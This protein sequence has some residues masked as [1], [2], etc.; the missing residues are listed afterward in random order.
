MGKSKKI[1]LGL[2]LIFLG[3]VTMVTMADLKKIKMVFCDVGQGDGMVLSYGVVQIVVDVGPENG[4]MVRCLSRYLPFWDKKIDL[5]LLSH[6]DKDHSGGVSEVKKYYQVSRVLSN[7]QNSYSGKVRENDALEVGPIQIDIISSGDG[8]DNDSSLV[9]VV[10]VPEKRILLM[11][12]VS[13]EVEQRLVWRGKIEP[14]EIIKLSHHGS[15]EASGEEIL[16]EAKPTEAIIS[17]GKNNRYGHP[18]KEVIERL[19]AKGIV[20]RRTDVEG[21]IVYVV[22]SANEHSTRP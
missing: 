4:K 17:V 8:V 9:M 20:T 22:K 11:G 15:T 14:V 1:V 16:L 21:D 3:W 18:G 19:K 7:E 10:K 12:D 13:R 5:V 6:G 2:S